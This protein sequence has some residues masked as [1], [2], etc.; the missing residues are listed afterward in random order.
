[1]A[2]LSSFSSNVVL[3]KARAMYGRRLTAQNYKEMLACH[4]VNELAA[5]LKNHTAYHQILSGINESDIHRGQLEILLRQ[6]IFEDSASLCRYDIS[7]GEH[8]AQ[9]VLQKA[10]I[11][12]IMH[13]VMHLMAGS[14]EE[15]LYAM[16]AFLNK[17]THID[18]LALGRIKNFD[19]LLL[20]LSHTPYQKI[21]E[22]FRPIPGQP[23]DYFGIENSLYRYLYTLCFSIIREKT[24]GETRSQLE[25]LFNVYADIENY[26]A[27]LRLKFNY[28]SGPD[29]IRSSLL[30]FGTFQ[31]RHI[32]ALLESDTPEE[33]RKVLEK[34]SFGKKVRL[35]NPSSDLLSTQVQYAVGSRKI[36]FSTHPS[37]V[38]LSYIFLMHIELHDITNIIEGIRYQIPSDEIA[39]LLTILNFP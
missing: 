18:L 10:E 36:R 29:F 22:R 12:Q 38:M 14:P 32:D 20:A 1:M 27:I 4:S 37:V 2:V 24:H 26:T 5:Y 28:H 13:S 17:H 19:D 15:Y 7:V 34:T 9:Y 35:L 11:E 21:L 6:K 25:E 31:P 23:L 33:M 39:S 16:P 8:F 3:A 30:P